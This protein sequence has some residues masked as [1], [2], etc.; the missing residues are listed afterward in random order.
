[1]QTHYERLLAEPSAA[2]R[3]ETAASVAGAFAGERLSERERKVSLD[4]LKVMARDVERQVREALSEHVKSSPLL[5]PSIARVLAA[6]VESVALP[7]IQ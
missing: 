7:I 5:P 1:M 3:A 4:I 2:V 6:D